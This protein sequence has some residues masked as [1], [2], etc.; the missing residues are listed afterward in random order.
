MSLLNT[1]LVKQFKSSQK[2]DLEIKNLMKLELQRQRTTLQMIPSENYASHAV[3]EACGSVLNNKYA[4]GYPGKRYYQGNE[5]VDGVEQLAIDRAKQLF[6]AEHANVQPHS[7]SP[8]NLAI[9]YALLKPGDKIMGMS[10]DMGGH[11]THGHKVNFSSKFYNSVQYGV[12]QKTGLLDMD[13]IRKLALLE[14]PQIIV[15]GATAY[16]RQFNFK[17]FHEIAE[18]VGAYS[19]ADISHI[20]GLVAG[21]VHPSPFPFTDVVMTTTHKT[22]RGPRGALILS[23]KEDRLANLEG[24]DEKQSLKEKNLARKIDTAIFPALQGGPHQ[25]SI[26]GKA[27]SFYEALQPEFSDYAHQVIK[28]AKVLAETLMENGINLVSG[29]TDNHLILIDLINSDCLAKP[30]LGKQVAVSLEKAGIVANANSIPYDPSTPFK[31]SGIRLGTPA[32]TTQGMRESEMK[33]IGYLIAKVIK[34][35]DNQEVIEKIR[36]EVKELCDK[37]PLYR[38]W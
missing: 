2:M 31:P 15:S 30:G 36:G 28:N 11:L 26:A 37:F 17:F 1:K 22:L 7:G 33:L 4:E 12:D 25:H 23:K 5:A 18:E 27:I 20:A 16:P 29:G 6:G 34:N 32:L 19:L 3:L 14:K 8:A 24:L 38:E 10:L 9:Y 13:K 21:G 35:H